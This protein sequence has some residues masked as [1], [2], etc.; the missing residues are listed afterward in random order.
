MSVNT[1]RAY[2]RRMSGKLRAHRRRDVVERARAF[3]LLLPR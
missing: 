3:G 1:V 2:M